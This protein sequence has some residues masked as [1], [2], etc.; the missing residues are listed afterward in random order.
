MASGCA[1]LASHA[2][3]WQDIIR[4][5]VDGYTVPC[6]DRE[7]V[8]DK[9]ELLLAEPEQLPPLGEAGRARVED[10]YSIEREAA[11]LCDYYRCLQKRP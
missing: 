6:D 4:E 2:G 3:A 8:Q 9:L 1:V 7:A 10:R 11:A 5:G